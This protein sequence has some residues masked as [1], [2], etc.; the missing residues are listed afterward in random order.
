MCC[1]MLCS[2]AGRDAWTYVNSEK[3][4]QADVGELRCGVSLYDNM[5]SILSH[6]NCTSNRPNC[7]TL[8][9]VQVSSAQSACVGVQP[10]DH[11]WMPFH[12]WGL[13]A[14]LPC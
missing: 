5:A 6:G 8:G 13:P 3:D 10:A 7:G 9:Q 11:D 12:C 14:V 1:A 2:T 4:A